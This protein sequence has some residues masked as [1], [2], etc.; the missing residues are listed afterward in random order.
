MPFYEVYF[1]AS[2]LKIT[3]LIIFAKCKMFLIIPCIITNKEKL[4]SYCALS[5]SFSNVSSLFVNQSIPPSVSLL[6]Y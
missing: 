2:P 5:H 4:Y 1:C 3:L 6:V